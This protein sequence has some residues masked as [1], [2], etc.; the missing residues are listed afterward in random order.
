[1]ILKLLLIIFADGRGPTGQKQLCQLS[2][3]ANFYIKQTR[4]YFVFQIQNDQKI[5]IGP[6]MAGQKACI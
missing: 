1:M 4:K 5:L 6:Y 3:I 2:N